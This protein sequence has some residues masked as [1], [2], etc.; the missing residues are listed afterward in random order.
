VAFLIKSFP[1]H[2][3]PFLLGCV[4]TLRSHPPLPAASRAEPTG[5]PSHGGS[6]QRPSERV[7]PH[8][9]SAPP[10]APPSP[11]TLYPSYTP[12]YRALLS[13]SGCAIHDTTSRA[14]AVGP[15]KTCAICR[16]ELPA[17]QCARLLPCQHDNFCIAC[18]RHFCVSGL[19]KNCPICRAP[20]VRFHA[21]EGLMLR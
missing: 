4:C 8:P 9:D 2:T 12:D 3:P 19:P 18:I 13:G 17:S 20:F 16:E 14:S 7:T 21:S 10:R 6:S 11:L 1:L 5:Y 15:K